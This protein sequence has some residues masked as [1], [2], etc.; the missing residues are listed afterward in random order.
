MC[1]IAHTHK[2]TP[3]ILHTNRCM[4]MCKDIVRKKKRYLAA[5]R[6]PTQATPKVNKKPQRRRKNSSASAR[7]TYDNIIDQVHDA[8]A[9][10][11]ASKK[12][13]I[14]FKKHEL[15]QK[16]AA[17]DKKKAIAAE[18]K[19]VTA[20]KKK[21]AAA[22]KKKAAAEKKKAAAAEKKKVAA[23]KKKAA[24]EKRAAAAEKRKAVTAEKKKAAAERKKTAAEKKAAEKKAAASPS[25]GLLWTY[26]LWE[27]VLCKYPGYDGYFKGEIYRRARGK[28]SVYFIEDGSVRTG[29]EACDIKLPDTT[30][31]W[32]KM[33][34]PEFVGMRYWL[35]QE[36]N[37]KKSQ[38]LVL[39]QG[40]GKHIHDYE[41]QP[42]VGGPSVF[43]KVGDVQLTILNECSPFD[44]EFYKS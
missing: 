16:K 11:F 3:I 8:A 37:K 4:S 41:C 19:V 42:E 21:T 43:F 13:D 38:F 29:V 22:E 14:A 9:Q 40:K 24:A 15:R 27:R 28:Y 30:E 1:N 5:K 18:K 10:D 7:K 17:A 33:T 25:K 6:K 34:R 39:G 2:K 12:Q 32:A 20:E 36:K 31:N 44:S 35:K 23:E 26:K